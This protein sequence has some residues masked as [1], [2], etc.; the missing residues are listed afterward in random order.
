MLTVK[1]QQFQIDIKT[2][3]SNGLTLIDAI[4]HWCEQNNMEIEY[5]AA[6]IKKDPVTKSLLQI[7]AEGLSFLK[8]INRLPLEAC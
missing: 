4:V 7:E 2:L 5:A 3:Q 1:H 8:K 6:M